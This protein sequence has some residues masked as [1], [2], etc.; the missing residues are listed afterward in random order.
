MC[1]MSSKVMGRF[2]PDEEDACETGRGCGADWAG[3]SGARSE[4]KARKKAILNVR[5]DIPFRAG[6]KAIPRIKG[7]S[8]KKKCT[9]QSGRG[10]R[11]PGC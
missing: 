6:L 10:S 7:A 8:A 5:I 9:P 3:Q 2:E 4:H 11:S 1:I